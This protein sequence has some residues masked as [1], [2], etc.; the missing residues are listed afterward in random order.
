MLLH[1]SLGSLPAGGPQPTRPANGP[2]LPRQGA[3][4]RAQPSDHNTGAIH[5]VHLRSPP[6][7]PQDR[8]IKLYQYVDHMV[9]CP[10]I[11]S[12]E[13][14]LFKLQF[15]IPPEVIARIPSRDNKVAGVAAS[16]F[17]R[18]VP[19][20]CLFRL[21]CCRLSRSE[22][23]RDDNESTWLSKRMVWPANIFLT[24]NDQCVETRASFHFGQDLP[25]DLTPFVIGDTNEIEV[26]I[27]RTDE[28]KR[29]PGL[30]AVAVETVEMASHADIVQMAH[31][32][33]DTTHDSR[34]RTIMASL[35]SDPKDD[36]LAVVQSKLTIDLTDPYTSKICDVPT[37]T[38]SCRHHDGFDFETF[39]H[40]RKPHGAYADAPSMADGWT[41][42]RCGGDAR[43]K[44]LRI[45]GYLRAVRR[46]LEIKGLLDTKAV[47]VAQ[48]GWT[49]H[50][51][52]G[53]GRG[54]R[55]ASTVALGN[56]NRDMSEKAVITLDD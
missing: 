46:E 2:L 42:P 10:T 9:L 21:R 15:N 22:G 35:C 54:A 32:K 44:Q 43:P 6:L 12:N 34:F 56:Q 7:L 13:R 16:A 23:Q 51:E 31:S 4:P 39:L 38:V 26:A 30:F 45:D 28:E 14:S 5:L 52:A 27:I 41:C 50:A 49:V 3:A 11:L 37:R 36:D 29:S 25:A 53:G 20:A 8:P 17:R 55:N 47:D 33:H 48:T 1:Q 40:T 24:V 18:A 19:G